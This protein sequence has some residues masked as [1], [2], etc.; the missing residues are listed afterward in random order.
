MSSSVGVSDELYLG[1]ISHAIIELA[2]GMKI[3]SF[4][5]PNH[6]ILIQAI[7]KISLL[8]EDI[9][10]PEQG[11]EIS[12]TKNH[13]LYN[14]NP[15]PGS[16]SHKSLVDLN[17]ELYIR[18]AA[19][20]I[21]LPSMMP[22][23]IVS[24]LKTI[25][26]DVEQV[27][28]DGGLEKILRR[29]KVSR[30]CINRVEYD[31]FSDVLKEEE[32]LEE[33]EPEEELEDQFFNKSLELELQAD[34]QEEK[35]EA[36]TA[37]LLLSHIEKETD[38]AKYRIHIDAFLRFML[39][40]PPAHK[41]EY[42]TR[43]ISIFIRHIE[44]PPENNIEIAEQANMGIRELASDEL[45]D[46]YITH[47]KKGGI[48]GRQETETILAALG[49]KAANPLL[50]ALAEEKD[51]LIRKTIV[52][53]V[54]RIGRAAVPAVLANLND[55]RWYMI[56][57]M[58][59]ILG[60]LGMPDLA[61]QIMSTLSN[62]DL[63]VKKEAIKALSR[64]NLPSATATLCELCFYPEESVALT[65]T[66]ALA[67]KKEFE[68]IETLFRRATSRKFLFLNYRLAHEAIDSLRAI[69]TE[70]AAVA[71][72]QILA[73]NTFLNTKKFRAMKTHT[74]R[75]LFSIK[76]SSAADALHGILQGNDE[77]LK[78]EA[79]RILKL[80]TTE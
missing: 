11:L 34:A 68:A 53:I 13:L 61:P 40:E 77:A 60:S 21:F 66:T 15:L 64:I 19:R 18:R 54:V 52:S 75:S 71:L 55:S 33:V 42:S 23:E 20:V 4:Y 31:K 28:D 72:E 63:R 35:E 24:F 27:L 38:P 3:V 9:P 7:T 76:G 12:V 74:L 73:L 30:I 39:L 67:S 41:I 56:R 44:S 2:K 65:A 43:A 78:R 45:I 10:L 36:P 57:N 8:F 49:E 6:P 59:M 50:Q 80:K 32:E 29:E 14:N 26:R 47:L 16:G 46:H 1:R 48:R 22:D 70:E 69:G 5:P 17:R 62:P 37:D 51:I 25:S 58:V 79:K